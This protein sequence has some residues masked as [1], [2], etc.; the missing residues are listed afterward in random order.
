MSFEVQPC[1]NLYDINRKEKGRS[2][3]ANKNV[4][5]KKNFKAI[6]FAT[7]CVFISCHIHV[8]Q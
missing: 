2:Q 5:L 4:S 3:K 8:L 1:F 6:N 7:D